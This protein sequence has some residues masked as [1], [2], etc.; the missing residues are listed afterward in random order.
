[1]LDIRCKIRLAH[2]RSKGLNMELGRWDRKREE[3]IR[4]TRNFARRSA[5]YATGKG[6]RGGR[7]GRRRC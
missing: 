6:G 1:M 5:S 7:D 3:S 2:N 4:K